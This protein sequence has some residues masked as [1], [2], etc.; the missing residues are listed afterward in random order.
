M[1]R[2][3]FD[4]NFCDIAQ[5][6][7]LP[8]P[9]DGSCTQRTE[10]K[11][12]RTWADSTLMSM[13]KA[14]L[15]ECLRCAEHNQAVAEEQLAQHIEN[16]KDWTPVVRCKDC[17]HAE[18]YDRMDGLTGC[19]CGHPE[20]GMTYGERWDRYFKPVKKADDYCSYGKRRD[21]EKR[22]NNSCD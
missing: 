13:K 17:V 21:D 12:M 2:L 9:Y 3:T 16:V 6:R 15:I 18:P 19:Y 4:G 1:E 11:V 20:N 22:G 7:E 10:G 8:C 5:C 14:D